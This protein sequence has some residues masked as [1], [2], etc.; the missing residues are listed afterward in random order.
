MGRSQREKGKRGERQAVAELKKIGCLTS[1]RR[2]RNT[3]GD[4]DIIDAIEGVSFECKLEK[5]TSIVPA[6]LQ[7][8]SQAGSDVPAVV[9]RQTAEPGQP[10]T[11]WLLTMRLSDLPRLLILY[12]LELQGD[13]EAPAF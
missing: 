3:E 8:I 5:R 12:K 1:A 7:A 10:A 6:M 11:P 4:S 9:H 13:R 2:V